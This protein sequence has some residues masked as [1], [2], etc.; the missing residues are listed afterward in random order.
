MKLGASKMGPVL[1]VFQAS[2]ICN[3][4]PKT[5]TNWIEAGHINAYKTVGGHR[6]I[7]RA[8]MI[9][10]MQKQGI[11]LPEPY[12]VLRKNRILVVDDDAIVVET[13]V[14]ALKED[15]NGYEVQSARDGFE[16]GLK[17]KA[18]R[19]HLIV[20][21]IMMPGI[22]GD[23]V[24]KQIKSNKETADI[25]I[26]VLSA[27]LDQDTFKKMKANGADTC[28]SKPL[29]IPQFKEEIAKLMRIDVS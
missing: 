22:K 14:Q 6:R 23:E 19:P 13:L 20:L 11:P 26:L 28:F 10:F 17:V 4:S 8:D 24:C 15:E 21:D 16:A 29:Q 1:T 27:Y 18:F 7:Q 3:V 9:A 12:E 5:I 25:K 2:K